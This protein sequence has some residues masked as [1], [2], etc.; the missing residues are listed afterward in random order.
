MA[1]TFP[2]DGRMRSWVRSSSASSL[3]SESMS[4]SRMR[5]SPREGGYTVL[6]VLGYEI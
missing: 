3:K 5:L 6:S 1:C 4:F 2:L